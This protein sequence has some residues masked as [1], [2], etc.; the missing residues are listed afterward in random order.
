MLERM[1]V[2]PSVQTGEDVHFAAIKLG[3]LAASHA[4]ASSNA[5]LQRRRLG[6]LPATGNHVQSTGA[7]CVP[8]E[9]K[10]RAKRHK[11]GCAGGGSCVFK[12]LYRVQNCVNTDSW[13]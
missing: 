8:K 13:F 11:K 6:F 1:L 5:D 10:S 7:S 9:G 12:L 4:D 3:R 2:P